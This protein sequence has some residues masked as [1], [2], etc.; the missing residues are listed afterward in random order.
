MKAGLHGLVRGWWRGEVGVWGRLLDVA[1]L[2]LAWAY[3]GA[4]RTRNR[5]ADRW[6]G[7]E[8]PG[9]RVVSVGNLVV[10]GTGKTPVSAWAAR[11]LCE[12]G[13][14]VALVCRGYGGDEELLHRR[15]N[16]RVRVVAHPD[17]V[18]AVRDARARGAT[19]AVLDDGFQHRRLARQVDLV[20]LAA[21]DPFPGRLLP[22]GP[23][24]E[25]VGS[26]RRA[27]GVIVTRRTASV[28]ASQRLAEEVSRRFPQLVV[29]R[30][31]LL[32]GGWRT[33]SG[34]AAPE[35]AGP[36][37]TVVGVARPEAVA[38][39][40]RAATGAETELVALADHQAYGP[41]DVER[42]RSLA[43]GRTVVVTEKDAVKLQE[44]RSMLDPVRVLTQELRW[45]AGEEAVIDLVRTEAPGTV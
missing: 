37:L 34:E 10:G 43:A 4:V 22:R 13:G 19:A 29:G 44:Y 33:L 14:R 3:A 11:L 7:V 16:P 9:I 45:E 17:R 23:Y 6:G 1:A 30:L 24:R 20:L 42:M 38:N 8:V 39:Q 32:P 35:P 18:A 31:A 27:H 21:E 41:R 28:E 40:V 5:G 12:S 2:P 36:T 25:P 26:L 15:W